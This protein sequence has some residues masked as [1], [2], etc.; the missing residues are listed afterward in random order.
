[1][2]RSLTNR[3]LQMFK[4]EVADWMKHEPSLTFGKGGG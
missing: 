2:L 3:E 1:V 4:T